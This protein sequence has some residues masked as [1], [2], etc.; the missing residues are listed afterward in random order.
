M[1]PLRRSSWATVRTR[2]APVAPSGWPMA[3][4]PPFTFT[5]SSG[6]PSSLQLGMT[7][8]AKASLNSTRSILSAVMPAWRSAF[9]VEGIG[10][11]PI[12]CGFTPAM[13]KPTMRA[14]GW[15]P[16]SRARFSLMMSAAVN[17]SFVGQLLPAVIISSLPVGLT[18]PFTAGSEPSVS[19]F[20]PGRMHSSRSKMI[21][22]PCSASTQLPSASKTGSS[23]SSGMISSL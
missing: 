3:I 12:T 20:V 21:F 10:P 13:P 7:W 19:M 14:S 2:R 4:E 16:S 18:M 11:R 15:R 1:P 23:T 9:L 17:P 6:M 22:L 8:A 5:R